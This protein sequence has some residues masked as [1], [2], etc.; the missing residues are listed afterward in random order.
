MIEVSCGIPPGPECVAQARVAEELGYERVWLYDSPAL[1]PDVWIE[2]A[3]VAEATE[4]IGLGPA[5]L[6]PSL[7][8]VLVTANAIATVDALAPGRL[9]VAV[10]TGFTGRMALGQRP[11]PW[12]QVAEYLRRLRGLLHGDTVE[13]DGALVRLMPPAGYLPLPVDVPI[14]VAANGPKGLEVARELGDGV[15]TVGPT[16]P[17][18]ETCSVLTFGTVLDPAEDPGSPRA[19]AAA[20]PMAAVAYH[21]IYETDPDM[22]E[23][24]PGG[25]EWRAEVD[26]L[27]EAE[28]HLALH[29]EH[30]VGVTERDRAVV[31]G[32]VLRMFTWTG[33]A[34]ELRARLD[35]LAEA[36][37]SEVLF[38]AG[39][40]DVARELRA[41]HA[42]ATGARS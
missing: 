7:R 39:G 24:L 38:A 18:F 17:E 36:G 12:A 14:L 15:M 35:A 6:V 3:R 19:L 22:V 9:T 16:F 13:V 1:Y 23:G 25:V 5:V 20:G 34:A 27:P 40:P 30:F 8:H 32:D 42:M 31:T 11:L 2:L 28:R 33:E 29:E 4:R 26:A 41:F 10:G 37:A 21:G